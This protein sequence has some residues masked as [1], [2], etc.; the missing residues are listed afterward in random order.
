M[1]KYSDSFSTVGAGTGCTYGFNLYKGDLDKNP[2]ERVFKTVSGGFIGFVV[3]S[4]IG[5]MMDDNLVT[6]Y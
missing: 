3:G 2:M 5:K 4:I 1:G 6:I